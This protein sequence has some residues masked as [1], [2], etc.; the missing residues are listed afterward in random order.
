MTEMMLYRIHEKLLYSGTILLIPKLLD[1]YKMNT[2]GKGYPAWFYI[3]NVTSC[4]V[5]ASCGVC[6]CVRAVCVCVYL[7]VKYRIGIPILI[8]SILL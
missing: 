3:I 2:F 7:L 6:V 1:H 8:M 4:T 5:R